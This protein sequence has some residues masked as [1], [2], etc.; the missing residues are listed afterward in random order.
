MTRA[1]LPAGKFKL[2]YADPAWQ[3]EMRSDKGYEKSPDAHYDC[4]SLDEL[5]AM[6]AEVI[7]AS[8][9]DSVCIM[10]TAFALL[11]QALDLMRCWGFTYKTGG[12][13]IKRAG[14][15]NPAMGT[16]YVLRSAAELFLIGTTGR[17]KTKNK[18]TRNVLL[19]GEWPTTVEELD[20]VIV[21]TLRREHSRKPD[22]MIPLIE[23]L[24]E[25][26]Y[27]ELFARTQREGWSVWGNQTEKFPTVTEAA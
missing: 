5:K 16:G 27:L 21:D 3:Y 20:S 25:G 13:W 1:P 11:P 26:P 7:F 24:F 18:G 6:A 14:T 17:P 23:A 8:D 19:T 15:G 2:I 4:M 10:W 9:T 22:E 12:P